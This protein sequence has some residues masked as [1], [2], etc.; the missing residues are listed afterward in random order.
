MVIKIPARFPWIVHSA[1]V[2]NIFMRLKNCEHLEGVN[3]S[4]KPTFNA[5]SSAIRVFPCLD[6]GTRGSTTFQLTSCS[7][8]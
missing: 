2:Q 8:R 5:I 1:L 7:Y 6:D 4:S 3:A